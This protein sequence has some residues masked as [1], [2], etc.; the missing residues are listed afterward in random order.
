MEQAKDFW[1]MADKNLAERWPKDDNGQPE[2]AE[3]LTL[4]SELDGMADITLSMLEGFGIPAFKVGSQGKVVLGFAGL[5]VEIYVPA[6]RLEE[7]KALL[8]TGAARTVAEAVEAVDLSRSAFY[9]YKD[10]IAPFR[11]MKRDNITTLHIKLHDKPGKLAAVLSIFTETGANILTINQSIP[12]NGVALVT[13]SFMAES[14]A[15]ETDELISRLYSVSGVV[16]V[17]IMAG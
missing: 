3:K 12:A 15:V 6:S 14:V 8:E 2:K 16:S 1:A 11:D 13:V 9:K 5:G 17:E 10:A 7:A 4:Q